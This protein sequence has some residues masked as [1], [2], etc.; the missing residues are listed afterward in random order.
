MS[1]ENVDAVRRLIGAISSRNYEVVAE[2]LAPDAQWHNT[3][4]FPGPTT[5]VGADAIE[6]FL[7]D[8]FEVYRGGSS[9]IEIEE[10]V[11]AGETVIVGLHG[12]GHGMS[13]G[14]PIDSRWAHAIRFS[15]VKVARVDTYGRFSSA[16][17]AA[18]LRD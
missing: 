18:G 6:E 12:W 8:L 5:V 11:D 7:R 2:Y 10:L 4:V 13:S 15:G 1:Q 16:L 3:N 14:V 9:G 17:E